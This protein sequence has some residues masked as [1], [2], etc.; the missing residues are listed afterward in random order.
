MKNQNIQLKIFMKSQKKDTGEILPQT[1]Q[2]DAE[3]FTDKGK[4]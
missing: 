4:N 3:N 1:C 2:L